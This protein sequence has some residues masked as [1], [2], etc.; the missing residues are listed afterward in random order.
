MRAWLKPPKMWTP[1]QEIDDR[2]DRAKAAWNTPLLIA[3]RHGTWWR[4]ACIG[5]LCLAAFSTWKM[6]LAW[7][8]RTIQP[9]VIEVSE[10]GQVRAVG[11]VDRAPYEPSVA[12]I[13]RELSRFVEEVRGISSDPVV[14]RRNWELAWP[15]LTEKARRT[16]LTYLQDNDPR[17]LQGKLLVIVEV[18]SVLRLSERSYQVEWRETVQDAQLQQE[19]V[20]T[21]Y[22]GIF[23]LMVAPPKDEKEL[24]KNP[25]GIYIDVFTWS[26]KLV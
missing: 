19:K 6:S 14:L 1:A 3:M 23:H 12:A 25:L 26:K 17:T 13:Q 18:Q 8:E 16:M 21:T 2:Y 20:V 15:L 11:L 5:G 24:L 9:Y 7:K 4:R 10:M 22:A